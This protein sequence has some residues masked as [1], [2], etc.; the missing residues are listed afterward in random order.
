MKTVGILE[1][2]CYPMDT[3][4][5]II[6]ACQAYHDLVIAKSDLH[7]F[8]GLIIGFCRKKNRKNC[9]LFWQPIFVGRTKNRLPLQLIVWKKTA[10]RTCLTLRL[11]IFIDLLQTAS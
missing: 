7:L 10:L 1:R 8:A 3:G 9:G 11:Q 2:D 4:A 6:Y 5:K